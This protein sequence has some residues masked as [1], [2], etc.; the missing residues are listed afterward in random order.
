MLHFSCF[1]PL[2]FILSFSSS[3]IVLVFITRNPLVLFLIGVPEMGRD[4]YWRSGGPMAKPSSTSNRTTSERDSA[5]TTLSGCITAVFHLF[6]SH[7]F[8]CHLKHHT[9]RSKLPSLLSR[10]STIK[11]TDT[12]EE[13]STLTSASFTSTTKEEFLNIPTGIQIKTRLDIRSKAGAPN[14][15]TPGTRTPTLVARLM[16]L[17]LLPESHSPSF[18]AK[19]RL[20]HHI[21]S[22]KSGHKSSLHGD[23]RGGTRSLSETPRPSSARRSDVDY[24]H[25]RLSLQINKENMSACEE[26]VMSRLSSLKMKK[27]KNEY[28]IVEQVKERLKRKVGMNITNAVR[29][30]QR[31]REELVSKFK[32]KRISRALTKVADDSS[33][34]NHSK[35]SS[36]IEFR[37]LES[38]GKPD[39][40]SSTNYHN[41]QPPKLSF[42][43]SPDTDIQL[44]PIRVL[45]KPKLQAVEEEQEEQ[46]KLQQQQ[47]RAV[48]KCKKGPNQKFISRLKKPQQASEIIRN[49]KE[50]PFVRPSRLDIPD[51]K[52]RKTHLL[53]TTVPTLL[54]APAAKI[55]QK[56]VLDA[57]RP[58]Y[59]SQ[60]SSSTQT[61]V[62]QEPRQAQVSTISTASNEA[63]Y[64]YIARIL[65]RSGIDKDTPVSFSSW[66][67]PSHPLDPSIFNYVERFTTCSAN[68][69]G[70][71][72]QRC[73]RKLL[74]HLVDELLSGILK[75]Y[76]N[77]KPWVIRVGPGFSYMDGS[78]LIDTLCSKIRRFPQ[79]GCRVLEDIDALIDKDLPD[80]KLQSVMAYEEEG[81]A[82]VAELEKGILEALLHEMAVEF[83]VRL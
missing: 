46:H 34:V 37:F 51:K 18:Q 81:E 70:K 29:N 64:E 1:S 9:S 49:K 83:G 75:P 40:N 45:P 17:D 25:H 44:Q 32:F 60:L 39:K 50:E 63:E 20:S 56:K 7:R 31:D 30:R 77:M 10:D 61:Y 41:L 33:I 58:K 47:P 79:S 23:M 68:D 82:I 62:K 42:S 12:E 3:N 21:Q 66:F 16:G 67:S 8:R 65:R 24:H 80:I 5:Q 54:P 27:L 69:N 55:P 72:S 48:S 52:C 11:G 13:A 28:E 35:H 4:W 26:L 78:Q 15:E 71:L 59:S 22:S 2:I 74:F 73:N 53:S 19:S 43:S 6:G 14:N 76:F 57:Q 38:K 36:S